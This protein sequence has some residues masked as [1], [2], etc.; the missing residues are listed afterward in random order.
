MIALSDANMRR[1]FILA[2]VL[3]GMRLGFAIA[4]HMMG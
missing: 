3:V 1:Y 2:V 4:T